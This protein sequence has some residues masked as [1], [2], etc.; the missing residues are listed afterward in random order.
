MKINKN[1]K[2]EV[3]EEKYQII[4]LSDILEFIALGDEEKVADIV[5]EIKEQ[6]E[7]A[8]DKKDFRERIISLYNDYDFEDIEEE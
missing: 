4:I 1:T 8:K 5:Q 3:T 7:K 2:I 6:Y